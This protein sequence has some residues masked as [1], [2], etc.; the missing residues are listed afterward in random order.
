M[1]P[2]TPSRRRRPLNTPA[3]AVGSTARAAIDRVAASPLPARA[4]TRK[5]ITFDAA[6]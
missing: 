6:I 2:N 4:Q 3:P 5:P 1:N